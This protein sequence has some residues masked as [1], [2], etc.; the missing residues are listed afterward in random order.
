MQAFDLDT[1][2]ASNK[3]G[4]VGR[5]LCPIAGCGKSAAP[6]DL[7]ISAWMDDASLEHP[8]VSPPPPHSPRYANWI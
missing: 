3:K 1:F 2:I 5:W 8:Y 4:N 6:P 7:Y